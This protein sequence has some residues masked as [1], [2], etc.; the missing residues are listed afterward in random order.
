[1]GFS[2]TLSNYCIIP[3]HCSKGGIWAR[4][5]QGHLDSSLRH[6]PSPTPP[7]NA[8]ITDGWMEVAFI[9]SENTSQTPWQ[10]FGEGCKNGHTFFGHVTLHS[11]VRCFVFVFSYPLHHPRGIFVSMQDACP[12][13]LSVCTPTLASIPNSYYRP[14]AARPCPTCSSDWVRPGGWLTFA[15]C[16]CGRSVKGWAPGDIGP[17]VVRWPADR[18]GC[19]WPLQPTGRCKVR[20]GSRTAAWDTRSPSELLE[21]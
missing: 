4:G 20:R 19:A 13:P 10:M 9:R 17:G 14:G 15:K 3:W 6:S 8:Y 1:M 21:R 5:E 11:S 7:L 16:W 2:T 18:P 12:D